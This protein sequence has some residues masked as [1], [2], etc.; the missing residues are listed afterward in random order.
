MY[1][2]WPIVWRAIGLLRNRLISVR[3]QW[4]IF[5]PTE[6]GVSMLRTVIQYL[7]EVGHQRANSSVRHGF[8]LLALWKCRLRPMDS[9]PDSQNCH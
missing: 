8:P 9:P 3:T 6:D 5:Q 1:D 7:E 2:L 4:R